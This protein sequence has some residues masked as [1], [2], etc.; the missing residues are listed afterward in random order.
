MYIKFSDIYKNNLYEV[1][2]INKFEIVFSNEI[3]IIVYLKKI[4]VGAP[5]QKNDSDIKD[6]DSWWKKFITKLRKIGGET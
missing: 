1:V 5:G 6:K 2:D 4:D 3:D